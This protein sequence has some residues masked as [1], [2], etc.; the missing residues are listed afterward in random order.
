M[1]QGW[2]SLASIRTA[3]KSLRATDRHAVAR[4]GLKQRKGFSMYAAQLTIRS[5][6]ERD[7]L[8]LTYTVIIKATASQERE[9]YGMEIVN[10]Q[11]VDFDH[12]ALRAKLWS[13]VDGEP[14]GEF[15][16]SEMPLALQKYYEAL[17]EQD[18]RHQFEQGKLHLHWV[19]LEDELE[20]E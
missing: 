14:L 1:N 11:L 13:P 20:R 3:N 7:D 2:L 15:D 9:F 19:N 17:V 12:M 18:I 16:S 8:R 5:T 10:Q 6:I 4:G